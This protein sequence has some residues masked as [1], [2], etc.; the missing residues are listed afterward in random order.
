[1]CGKKHLVGYGRR[2]TNTELDAVLMETHLVRY[3]TGGN[4]IY[5]AMVPMKID[6]LMSVVIVE[7]Y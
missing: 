3:G 2:E 4:N 1:M 7:T 6:I 5:S